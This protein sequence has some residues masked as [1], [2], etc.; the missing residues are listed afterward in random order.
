MAYLIL[1]ATF[2]SL[3]VIQAA[4]DP[5]SAGLEWRWVVPLGV[6][7]VF[8]V[9]ALGVD[10]LTPHKKIAT[11]LGVLLGVLA[12]MLATLAIGFVID[13]LL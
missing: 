6:A 7:V 11:V 4:S 13:L 9:L 3:A 2:A 8:F 5:L 12:G 1:M 10:V